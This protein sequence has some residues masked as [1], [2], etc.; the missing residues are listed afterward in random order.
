MIGAHL[1]HRC[2]VY[3]AELVVDEYENR[4][5]DFP[6]KPHV[7]GVS[8]LYI[9]KTRTIVDRVTNE[10]TSLKTVKLFVPVDTDVNEGDRV[11]EIEL[12]DET[13]T[14]PFDVISKIPHRRARSRSHVTLEL[15]E[16]K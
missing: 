6:E 2:N 7:E 8:C 10:A 13:L 3:R 12:E 5:R 1:K 16:V 15:R 4:R 9:V 14:G 11:S